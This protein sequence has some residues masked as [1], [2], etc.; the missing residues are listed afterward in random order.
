MTGP[1]RRQFIAGLLAIAV[2]PAAI[3]GFNPFDTT[4]DL[5]PLERPRPVY[6]IDRTGVYSVAFV[7]VHSAPEIEVSVLHNGKVAWS[8]PAPWRAEDGEAVLS[9]QVMLHLADGDEVDVETSVPGQATFRVM[10]ID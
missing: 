5:L 4:D 6:T 10:R 7:V 1:T 3:E 2:V 8:T 9:G